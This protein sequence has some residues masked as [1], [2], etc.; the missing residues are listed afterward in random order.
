MGG[1][2]LRLRRE[3][4]VHV[5]LGRK[6]AALISALDG[7]L[8]GTWHFEPLG[9]LAGGTYVRNDGIWDAQPVLQGSRRSRPPLFSSL[10]W[11]RFTYPDA[12]TMYQLKIAL[13]LALAVVFLCLSAA[14]AARHR[15]TPGTTAT[16]AGARL[17]QG[18]RRNC[19][20]PCI[21]RLLEVGCWALAACGSAVRWLWQ[22]LSCVRAVLPAVTL[23]ISVSS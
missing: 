21:V 4:L 20:G 7:A 1:N 14:D 3:G 13:L 12:A 19:K 9:L 11:C 17:K 5:V 18:G 15:W 8:M 22:V 16:T 2:Q 10:V 23:L 6:E